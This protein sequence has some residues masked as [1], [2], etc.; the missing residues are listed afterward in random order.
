MSVPEVLVT[1][2]FSDV[3]YQSRRTD[4]TH[5]IDISAAIVEDMEFER[6]V[7][8]ADVVSETVEVEEGRPDKGKFSSSR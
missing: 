2:P 3:H 7:G 6:P 8:L 4:S 1:S 5:R